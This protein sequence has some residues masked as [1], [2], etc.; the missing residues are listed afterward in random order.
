MSIAFIHEFYHFN[1][2]KMKIPT[3]GISNNNNQDYIVYPS[4][5]L[6]ILRSQ[7]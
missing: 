4:Q 1:A 2:L 7:L 3:R 6:C 5:L